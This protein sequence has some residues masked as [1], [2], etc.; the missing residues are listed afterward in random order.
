MPGRLC[1]REGVS[2]FLLLG[3]F[4]MLSQ[5]VD[6]KAGAEAATLNPKRT[7]RMAARG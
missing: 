7:L 1:K 3:L 5:K 6:V 4:W 2:V